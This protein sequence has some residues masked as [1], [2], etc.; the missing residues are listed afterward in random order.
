MRRVQRLLLA[1]QPLPRAARL[2][3][4]DRL[5]P[6]LLSSSAAGEAQGAALRWGTRVA[7][8]SVPAATFVGA[9][10]WRHWGGNS[11]DPFVEPNEVPRAHFDKKYEL[12]RSLGKGGF[13]EVWLAV[14]RSSGREV[15]VKVLPLK[16]LP[17]SFVEQEVNA[18]RRVG[19][20]PNVVELLDVFWIKPDRER[21][22]GE[23]CLVMELAGGGGLFERLVE[24]GAYSEEY[25]AK[26]LRQIA[27]ALYHLHSRGIVHRDIKPENVVFASGDSGSSASVVKLIDFGTAVALEGKGEKVSSG[28][29]IGTWSYWAPEQMNKQPYDFAVDMWSLGVLAYILLVGGGVS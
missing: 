8:M 9:Y 5:R 18:L 10:L 14:E 29:R 28:G 27:V 6:R 24:E 13:G 17:R 23:A 19:R 21:P 7:L 12:K 16:V 4:Q 2:L 3:R 11:D 20:H 22:F 25:A 26:I 1:Q 15:A